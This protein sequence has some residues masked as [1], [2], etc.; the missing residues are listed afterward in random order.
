MKE[1]KKVFVPTNMEDINQYID[2]QYECEINK[3]KL[4]QINLGY[5]TSTT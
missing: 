2:Y 1:E 3:N 5:F 4:Y